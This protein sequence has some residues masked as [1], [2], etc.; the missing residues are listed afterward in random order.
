MKRFAG[1]KYILVIGLLILI[2]NIATFADQFIS[3]KEYLHYIKTDLERMKSCEVVIRDESVLECT[4]Y[5]TEDPYL[6]FRFLSKQRG[7][8]NV[9]ITVDSE[10]GRFTEYISFRVGILGRVVREARFGFNHWTY[11]LTDFTVSFLLMAI[12]LMISFL[13]G[14]RKQLYSYRTMQKGGLAIFFSCMALLSVMLCIL[15]CVILDPRDYTADM[16]VFLIRYMFSF[17]MLG[18]LPFV[19]LFGAA[20]SVSNIRLI[21]RE[22]FRKVNLLGIF[23]SVMLVGGIFVCFF[24]PEIYH[25]PD[26]RYHDLLQNTQFTISAVFCFLLSFMLSVMI[27]GLV[28]A[29]RVPAFDKD[30]IVIL[31]C[32]VKEDGTLYPLLQGRVDRAIWFWQKQYEMTGKKAV[33]VPSGGKG[34]DE[35]ISEAEAMRNYL[36]GKDIPEELILPET[37]S[38]NTYQNMKFSKEIIEAEKEN[39]K[40]L[41]S[42]TNYHVLRSGI[43]AGTAGL[44]ADGIGS[45]TRWYFWPNAFV[46]EFAG[47]LFNAK[48]LWILL[49]GS[50]AA[51]AALISL[52][53]K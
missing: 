28:S 8:T 14:I 26:E 45:R 44:K 51:A 38:V 30:F 5:E 35:V 43:L 27:C 52:I 21:M 33:F 4:G 22:G 36:L 32:G 41:F 48:K 17:F 15:V 13:R 3:R 20:L 53:I 16:I 25:V 9:E 42:T 6:R 24:L 29:V 47:L 39:A 19:L 18:T 37:R 7:E 23:L 11:V 31:G 46:R 2:I 10:E 1:K 49:F 34:S 12:L 50:V 40:V